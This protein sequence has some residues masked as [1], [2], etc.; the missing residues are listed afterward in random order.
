M[1]IVRVIKKH[2][3]EF[4]VPLIMTKDD[5]VE[6]E[7]RETEWEGW[8]WCK[9]EVGVS[10]WVPESYL[11]S[12]PNEKGKYVSLQDYDAFELHADV[13]QELIVLYEVSCWARVRTPDDEEGWIPLENIEDVTKSVFIPY[14]E[15]EKTRKAMTVCLS[16]SFKFI[17]KMIEIES[18]LVKN[19]IQCLSPVPHSYRKGST[20]SEFT[21]D[22][23]SLSEA[24]R[25]GESERIQKEYFHQKVDRANIVYVVNPEGYVGASVTLEIGYTY[26]MKK[27]IFAM[28]PIKE[29][30][31]MGLVNRVLSPEKLV[32]ELLEKE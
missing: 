26:A 19:D 28:E 1:R 29:Y 6:G 25:L 31:V 2:T 24:Q 14:C 13:G 22:W 18:F 10:G 5:I 3:S 7:K 30:T 21:E 15:K 32:Q 20:P 9:N 23:S 16:G 12:L 27:P 4:P 11:K 8:L 17:E